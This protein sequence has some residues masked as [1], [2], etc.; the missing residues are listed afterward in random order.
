MF[1][2]RRT[3]VSRAQ[4]VAASRLRAA[5][6]N[7]RGRIARGFVQPPHTRQLTTAC[8]KL[9][10]RRVDPPSRFDAK[11]D[12]NSNGLSWRASFLAV[13]HSVRYSEPPRKKKRR[14]AA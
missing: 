8:K 2:V 5:V 9:T 11:E 4:P 1:H 7:Y 13:S 10:S 14:A 3:V 6:K 12:I